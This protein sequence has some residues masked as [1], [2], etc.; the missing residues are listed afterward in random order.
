VSADDAVRTDDRVGR[1][2]DPDPDAPVAQPSPP[3]PVLE[4]GGTHVTAALVDLG[5]GRVTPGAGTRRPLRGDASAAEL[6]EQI[7]SCAAELD[8]PQR[9]AWGVAV[10]GPFDYEHGV[11]RF[12]GVGK[13]DALNG[14]DVGA[15]LRNELPGHP[16]RVR[17]LNDATAFTIGEWAFGAGAGH[18]RVVGVTLGTGVG[19]GFL[20]NGAPVQAGEKVPPG[21]EVHHLE[22][23]GRPLEDTVSRRALLRAFARRA[24]HKGEVDVLEIADLARA[25]DEAARQVLWEAFRQLGLALAPWLARFDA[26][27][28][29]VGGSMS[30]SWDLVRP[31]LCAGM[32]TAVRSLLEGLEVLR[33]QDSDHAALLGAAW[34]AVRPGSGD[35]SGHPP[36][37]T[38]TSK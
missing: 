30:G 4:I 9:A 8:P 29:V 15:V 11:A 21:G 13:F 38:A 17:F 19:S 3:V 16:E 6:L 32:Q 24:P 35:T 25:G 27:A 37:S 1:V 20:A 31:P 26:S 10:P 22:I 34:H 5:A 33:A 7:V 36:A 23:D 18:D 14:V 28:L 2:A 12:E